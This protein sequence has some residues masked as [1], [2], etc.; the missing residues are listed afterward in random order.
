MPSRQG[1]D[2]ADAALA[3]SR[4]LAAAL[5]LCGWVLGGLR[6]APG[7]F[8]GAWG[9]PPRRLLSHSSEAPPSRRWRLRESAG[10]Q[11]AGPSFRQRPAA[12]NAL[13]LPAA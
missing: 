5:W 1:S 7:P 12:V 9:P 10:W 11:R 13:A 3:L 6:I 4:G 8:G 2:S